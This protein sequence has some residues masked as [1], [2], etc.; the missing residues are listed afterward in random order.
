MEL[1]GGWKMET[2]IGTIKSILIKETPEWTRY[3]FEMIDGK[4]YSTFDQSIAEGFVKGDTVEMSGEQKGKYWNMQTIKKTDKKPEIVKINNEFH[5]SPEE[6][7]CRALEIATKLM[8]TN[9][10]I[11]LYD[12]AE[13]IEKWILR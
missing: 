4:K 5:L 10:S 7:R 13:Q 11:P 6:V 3:E 1:K 12:T 8:K 9:P 2:K